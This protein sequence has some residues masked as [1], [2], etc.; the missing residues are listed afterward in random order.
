MLKT[1]GEYV[2]A[3]TIESG[4]HLGDWCF[5]DITLADYEGVLVWEGVCENAWSFHHGGD[6]EVLVRVQSKGICK[7]TLVMFAS[8]AKSNNQ[9]VLF[10][11]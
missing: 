10:F 5:Y 3:E 4:I 7:L 2:D 9:I 8:V 11:I 1:F 6:W